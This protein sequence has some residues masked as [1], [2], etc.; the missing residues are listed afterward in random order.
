MRFSKA[1]R[2]RGVEASIQ[3]FDGSFKTGTI[4][5]GSINSV[6]YR[7]LWQK[8]FADAIR[9][10]QLNATLHPQS[11]NVF[12]SLGEAYMDSGDKALA[13]QFYE[14]SLALD[15]DNSNALS[16]IKKLKEN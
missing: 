14:K 7:L 3:E 11:A 15:P 5:E 2:E 12:D 6:G 1:V 10:F 9:I 8:R 13:I 16:R 4:S